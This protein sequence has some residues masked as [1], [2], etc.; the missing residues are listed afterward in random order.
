M[1]PEVEKFRVFLAYERNYSGNT[2]R[3]YL[4]DLK[5]FI[6]FLIDRELAFRDG[7]LDIVSV[8]DLTVRAYIASLH[9]L[10]SKRS[11]SRKL[12]AIRTFFD[13]LMRD[14]PLEY[15]PARIVPTPKIEKKLPTFLTVDEVFKLLEADFSASALG[16]RD[17]AI[18]EV[19]YSSGIRVNELHLLDIDDVKL[20]ELLVRVYGKGGKERIVPIGRKAAHALSGYFDK[21]HELKPKGEFVF[22]NRF[23]GRLT[24]RSVGRVVKKYAVVAGVPKNVHPHVLRHSFATHLLGNGADL[25]SIQE[26]LGHSSLSTTQSYL[27]LSIEKIMEIYDKTHPRA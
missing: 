11:V 10:N 16:L 5:G 3:A 1:I 2:L 22:V 18:L 14:N 15:N 24:S 20:S 25:R 21:R 19:L 6:N 26:M 8:D 23:G 7:E 27:H 17:K 9:S 13:F 4:S 12:A